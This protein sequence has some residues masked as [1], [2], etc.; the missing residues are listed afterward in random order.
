MEFNI[1][2]ADTVE[3]MAR[4]T[5][6]KKIKENQADLRFKSVNVCSRWVS[7]WGHQDEYILLNK[8]FYYYNSVFY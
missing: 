6:H 2:M 1:I 7:E 3:M 4:T 5:K 8:Y